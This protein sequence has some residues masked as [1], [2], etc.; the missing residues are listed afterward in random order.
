MHQFPKIL[1]TYK[2]HEE[3]VQ[4]LRS[5]PSTCRKPEQV[6]LAHR[7]LE[8]F[9]LGYTCHRIYLHSYGNDAKND[10]ITTKNST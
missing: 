9:Y 3:R 1:A 2:P 8:Q 4:G 5:I 6:E 10:A 7:P